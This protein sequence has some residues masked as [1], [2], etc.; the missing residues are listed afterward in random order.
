M[1]MPTSQ[2]PDEAVAVG[3]NSAPLHYHTTIPL[4]HYTRHV[5]SDLVPILGTVKKL[6]VVGQF[7]FVRDLAS[8]SRS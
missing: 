6:F 2:I 4:Q 1:A 5:S 8:I 7:S 3:P